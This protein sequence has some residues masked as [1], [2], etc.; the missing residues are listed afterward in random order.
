MDSKGLWWRFL[1]TITQ[2][3]RELERQLQ[4]MAGRILAQPES[5]GRFEIYGPGANGKSAFIKALGLALS[6]EALAKVHVTNVPQ[7]R[8]QVFDGA[9]MP[10]VIEF[11]ASIPEAQRRP[12]AQVLNEL[13]GA[14]AEILAWAQAGVR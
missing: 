3:N 13:R 6:P 7:P 11:S 2:R 9:G 12:M 10:A 8:V 14:S 5:A 1:D 4:S